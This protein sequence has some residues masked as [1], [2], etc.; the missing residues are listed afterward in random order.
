MNGWRELDYCADPQ[1]AEPKVCPNHRAA[2]EVI[3]LLSKSTHSL[4]FVF[5][6]FIRDPIERALSEFWHFQA[7]RKHKPVSDE[8]MINYI[9]KT[10]GE[11]QIRYTTFGSQKI[12][13]T[14]RHDLFLP[15]DGILQLQGFEKYS[16]IGL[17]ERMSESL[18]VMREILGVTNCDFLHLDA[19]RVGGVDDVTHTPF[20][21]HSSRLKDQNQEVQ[22]FVKQADTQMKF[23]GDLRLVALVNSTLTAKGEAIFGSAENFLEEAARLDSVFIAVQSQCNRQAYPKGPCY[24]R[25]TGCGFTCFDLE[26]TACTNSSRTRISGYDNHNFPIFVEPK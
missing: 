9:N 5:I 12:D 19:K 11:Y 8:R 13:T 1:S 14:W 21:E 7:L 20:L 15:R 25:D 23:A 24:K 4:P 26:T 18:V 17:T 16:F 22:D 6:T 2:F 10:D 3:D